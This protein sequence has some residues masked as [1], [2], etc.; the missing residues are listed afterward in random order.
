TLLGRRFERVNEIAKPLR[1]N[2]W[3]KFQ[4]MSDTGRDGIVPEKSLPSFPQLPVHEPIH[5]MGMNCLERF[6][7]LV[8]SMEKARP[9]FRGQRADIFQAKPPDPLQFGAAR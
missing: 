2:F 5:I 1:E 9:L 6:Q 3:P 8:S 7:E 4:V